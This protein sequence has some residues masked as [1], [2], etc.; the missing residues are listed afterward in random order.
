[1]KTPETFVR[2]FGTHPLN[3]Q[4]TT[5]FLWRQDLAGPST[6]PMRPFPESRALNEC[7]RCVVQNLLPHAPVPSRPYLS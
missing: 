2:Y 5:G 4:P 1:M 6:P 7:T 3:T